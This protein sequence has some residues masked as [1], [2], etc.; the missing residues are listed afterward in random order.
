MRNVALIMRRELAAWVRGPAGYLVGAV[1]LFID[2]LIFSAWAV[3]DQPQ[4]S[5]EVLLRFFHA[6]GLTTMG[7][8]VML[9]MR[10]L[11]EDRS[12]GTQTLLFTSPVREGEIVLGKY[13]AGVIVITVLTLLS[14]YLPALILVHGKISWGHIAAGY[15]GLVMLGATTLAIGTFA[16]SFVPHPFFA[17]LL[18]AVLVGVLEFSFEIAMVS[19]PPLQELIA[20]LPPWRRHAL[21]FARGLFQLSDVVYFVS[22]IYFSLLGATRV[23]QSQRWR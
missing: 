6:S 22:V 9:S 10:M 20:Y 12:L 1:F 19:D 16:S 14:F 3:G 4:L 17:V 23:L 21:P 13:L 11:A 2:G 8:G 5:A 15:L 7:M 18:A